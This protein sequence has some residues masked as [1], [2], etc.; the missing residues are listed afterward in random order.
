M[1]AALA[2]LAAGP[3]AGTALAG[4]C[5]HADDAIDEAT[6]KQLARAVRCLIGEDRR[7]RD[8]R[9]LDP[10]GKLDQAAGKHNRTMLKE[11]CWSHDCPGEPGLERRIKNTGY[12]DN[13]DKW[14]FGEVFGC[15]VTP[16]AMLDEWTANKPTRRVLRDKG[17]RD[18]GIAAARDQVGQSECDGGNEVTYTVVV[19][20]RSG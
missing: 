18:I 14:R 9:R 2:L 17:Y 15:E 20:K 5:A 8:L 4:A 6:A 3:G 13:A 19:A 11:N 7:E 12:L 10:N 16:M 1:I